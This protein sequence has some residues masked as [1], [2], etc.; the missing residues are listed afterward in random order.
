MIYYYP[1]GLKHKGY[2]SNVSSSGNSVAQKIKF[3]GFEYQ[4]ELNLNWY[5][6]SAR[7]YDPA[8]GRWMNLDPLAEKYFD[9]SPYIYS[10]NNPIF[11]TDPDGKDVR[12][13]QVR[14]TWIAFHPF[15]YDVPKESSIDKS[16][17][18]VGSS[19]EASFSDGKGFY[20][21][22]DGNGNLIAEKN[23]QA[24]SLAEKLGITYLEALQILIE[25]GYIV[26]SN[27]ILNLKVG[28]IVK[29]NLEAIPFTKTS[30]PIYGYSGPIDSD[31]D[32]RLDSYLDGDKVIIVLE[33]NITKFKIDESKIAGGILSIIGN[34][35]IKRITGVGGS[36]L[37]TQTLGDGGERAYFKRKGL[38][39]DPEKNATQRQIDS[40][41]IMQ[42]IK[43]K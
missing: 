14:G 33:Y 5:D 32:G 42:S 18:N 7:N 43:L 12:P 24:T 36:F 31:G 23:D 15:G 37:S 29:T 11:F 17:N 26:D 9:I 21:K 35:L 20:W 40:A 41:T 39:L 30:I 16:S 1:F 2:N 34:K 25:Q 27:G 28:D 19:S 6:M 22:D 4:E 10:L 3:G 8:L 38:G 13:S